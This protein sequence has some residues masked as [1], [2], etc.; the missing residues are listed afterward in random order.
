M[1][2]EEQKEPVPVDEDEEVERV[3]DIVVGKRMLC[4]KC[5]IDLKQVGAYTMEIET[6]KYYQDWDEATQEWVAQTPGKHV[7]TEVVDWYCNEC[8]EGIQNPTLED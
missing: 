4:P 7:D 3:L 5:K 8:K 6:T 1:Q 2:E